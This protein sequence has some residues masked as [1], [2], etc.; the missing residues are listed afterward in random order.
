MNAYTF[1]VFKRADRPYYLV[2]FKDDA[3]NF[4]PPVSTKKKTEDE[5]KETAFK[6]L[7][8]GIPQKKAGEDETA[9]LRVNDLSLKEV[10]R[11]IRT[12]DEAL[13]LL[14]ELKRLN[15]IKSFVLSETPGAVDFIAYLKDFWDWDNS[16]Y[17]K[18]KK[19]RAHG[20]H[21]CHCRN[22]LQ[23]VAKF[24]EGFFNG[25][26]LGDITAEDIDAF[27]THVGDMELSAARKNQIIKAGFKALRWA[28]AKNKISIDPTRGHIMF[29][30]VEKKRSI[31]TPALAARAFRTVWKDDRAKL[32]N[33][34]ASVTGMRSG[35]ILAL[36]SGDLGSDCLFV[37][38]SWNR[39]DKMKTTKNNKARK[40]EIP[41][42]ELMYGLIELAQ[43][44]P[45]GVSPDSF[46]FWADI[47]KD[48]PMDARI[49][50]R[51]LREALM[52][53]G[54]PEEE[55]GKYMFH[56]WRHFFTSYMV[57]KLDRKLLKSQTGHLT[58]DMI[59][60]YAD[61]ETEGDRDIIHNVS[62][63]TFAGLLPERVNVIALKKKPL[64]IAAG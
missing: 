59:E 33:M 12:K 57:K 20:I 60:L 50:V 40:V 8:D 24:W 9:A 41:F 15:W 3:G 35:E 61:H 28:F 34:L 46:V 23:A 13:T 62:K 10:V 48:K 6:W 29:T 37:E 17:I 26:F 38:S 55:A 18:E 49:L 53:I 25:R 1:S 27:I 19:R 47:K 58:D 32:A 14:N 21:K 42:P 11:K 22:Q 52:Q 43:Q 56:G 4:L 45:W 63:E 7:R 64:M 16:P 30:G 31:L 44:N 54:L 2:S 39:M 5:A 36:R 51:E